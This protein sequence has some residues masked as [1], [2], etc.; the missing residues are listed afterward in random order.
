MQGKMVEMAEF[1]ALNEHSEVIFTAADTTQ[2]VFQ[3][4]VDLS[5]HLA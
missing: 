3:Q 4:A 5:L 2:I 1:T